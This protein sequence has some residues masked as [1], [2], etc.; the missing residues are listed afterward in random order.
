MKKWVHYFLA[1]TLVT[2]LLSSSIST[3]A[4]AEAGKGTY[5]FKNIN[6]STLEVT[7]HDATATIDAT[8][9]A[10]VQDQAT[11]KTEQLPTQTTDKNGNPV[12]LV[13]QKTNKGL[14]VQVQSTQNATHSNSLN[15]SQKSIGKCILGTGGGAVTGAGTLG[16]AG[17][18]VGTVTI[19]GIGTVSAGLVGGIAGAVGGGMTGAAASC[20]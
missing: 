15:V 7:L 3:N 11:G 8:G 10:F 2:L 16:L 13:Y 6:E 18:A 12:N 1:T 14:E 19:P 4:Y 9:T 5:E 20:F 17:A